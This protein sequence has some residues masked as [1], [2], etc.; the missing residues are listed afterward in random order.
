MGNNFGA[1]TMEEEMCRRERTRIGALY[2]RN[3]KKRIAGAAAA[4]AKA[5]NAAME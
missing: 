3:V 1:W 5:E 2:P 4:K